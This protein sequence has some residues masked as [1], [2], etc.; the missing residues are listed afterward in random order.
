LRSRIRARRR[1]RLV[2]PETVE[3]ADSSSLLLGNL[4]TIETDG[5]RVVSLYTDV[6]RNA[7]TCDLSVT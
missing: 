7:L 6:V 2:E 1:L 4:V 5:H 3:G